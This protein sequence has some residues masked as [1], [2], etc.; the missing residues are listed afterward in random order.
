ML[1]I[2]FGKKKNHR[3]SCKIGKRT[4][5]TRGINDA[6]DGHSVQTVY[7]YNYHKIL[8]KMLVKFS[9]YVILIFGPLHAA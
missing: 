3:D 4:S 5:T 7:N 8:L 1:R 2:T 6:N 9:H